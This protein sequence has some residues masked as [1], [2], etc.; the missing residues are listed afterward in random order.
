MSTINAASA[1]PGAVR[2]S[3]A[4]ADQTHHR[5]WQDVFEQAQGVGF[6]EGQGAQVPGPQRAF[7]QLQSATDVKS[8]SA[9]QA[10]LVPS[11]AVGAG[12]GSP[13]DRMSRTGPSAHGVNDQALSPQASGAHQPSSSRNAWSGA[14]SDAHPALSLRQELW[15]RA[16]PLS[17]QLTE[18]GSEA[19]AAIRAHVVQM[20]SGDWKVTLR[21]H[22]GLSVAQ[23]LAAAA[24]AVQP[25]GSVF[26]QISQVVLNGQLV[27]GET[28]QAEGAS[29]AS[30]T[31]EL[32]C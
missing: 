8:P 29:S 27:H 15:Q 31:F 10:R 18:P 12:G 4:D 30:S 19:Q 14:A 5:F 32:R 26:G 11:P 23:A 24:Q 3:G 28:D 16:S 9:P 1:L 2:V 21:A 20:A 7:D 6:S 22:R 17:H 13:D 25:D